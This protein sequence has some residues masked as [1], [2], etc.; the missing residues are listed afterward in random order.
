MDQD[1]A[2]KLN[3]H[4]HEI[5]SLK[6]R[7][8]ECEEQQATINKLVNS[9]DKLATNME[10]MLEEQKTQRREINELKQVPAEDFKY[11]KRLIVG[12]ILTGV[13][14]AILGAILTLVI[15]G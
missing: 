3:D 15:K 14:G 10:N 11:Y 12:C 13:V 2:I 5:S 7:V 6:H 1:V 8:K 4:D 9:V